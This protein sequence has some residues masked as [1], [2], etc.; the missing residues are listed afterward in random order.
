[1]QLI[2]P[3][4]GRPWALLALC[5][6]SLLL[7]VYLLATRGG[8]EPAQEVVEVEQVDLV[9]AE[10]AEEPP[11]AAD[12]ADAAAPV[13][14]EPG[15]PAAV[16]ADPEPVPDPGA[17][18]PDGQERVDARVNHS[19]ARTF[20]GAVA[21]EDSEALT[22]VFARLFQARLDLAR[23][24]QAGD[25]VQVLY[26]RGD[27]PLIVAAVYDSQKLGRELSAFSFHATGDRYPSWWDADGVEVTPRLDA[28]PLDD[29]EQIT[30]L[31]K[32]G[33]GHKGM[34]FKVPVGA[35]V[36]SPKSGSVVR[37][38]WNTRFN[39]NC[40]EIQYNDGVLA[41][42]LHLDSSDVKPGQTVSSGQVIGRSGNT[43][44]SYAPHLHYELRRG[45]K[46]LDPLTYH[47]SHS[48]SIPAGDRASFQ[49]ERDRMQL[50]MDGL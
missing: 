6:T 41:R 33:R 12:G 28:S 21:E 5:G 50:L 20:Q 46:V 48:R 49:A 1:M 42:F 7:N 31:L 11:V 16:P 34:D 44:R 29:F 43:G 19:I 15:T 26:E 4:G 13:A 37:V 30:A 9:E 23:D 22:S 32:D 35:P 36:K 2:E 10:V 38:N 8:S 39:G 18:L 45:D 24:L 47:G 3:P 40:V 14:G 25:R 27:I 17:R